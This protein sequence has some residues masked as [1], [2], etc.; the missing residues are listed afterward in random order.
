MPMVTRVHVARRQKRSMLGPEPTNPLPPASSRVAIPDRAKAEPRRRWNPFAAG[1]GDDNVES[2]AINEGVRIAW[3]GNF[4]LHP[5]VVLQKLPHCATLVRDETA[6]RTRLRTS[7]IYVKAVAIVSGGLDSVTLAHSLAQEADH[8]HLISFDYGQKHKRELEFAKRAA[9]RLEATWTLID[10]SAAGLGTL[11]GGSALTDPQVAVPDGHYAAENMKVTIVPN[12]NAIML[13]IA[14]AAA[15]SDGA[16]IVGL[17][18]HA[19][20]HFIYPDCRPEFVAAF[21]EMERLAMARPDLRIAAP[22]LTKTKAQIVQLGARLGVPF[23]QTWSCYKG[24]DLHCGTCGTCVER[25]EAFQLAGV[26]DPTA[27]LPS[28]AGAQAGG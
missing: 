9:N 20:D 17:A 4:G 19:G 13:A 18:V 6:Q 2:G 23:E 26:E 15:E 12:R 14:C 1:A 8:L 7:S 3:R 27:Y 16:G 25:R 5:R 11:L 28:S 21:E 24:G 10:L 22:F